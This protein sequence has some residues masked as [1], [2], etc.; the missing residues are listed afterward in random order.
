MGIEG[1]DTFCMTFFLMLFIGVFVMLE[2]A[3]LGRDLAQAGVEH[4]L[5]G[6]P[7]R[8]V[9]EVVR[10]G[11]GLGEVLIERQCPG[12]GAGHLGNLDRVGEPGPVMVTLVIDE[13]LRLVLQPTEGL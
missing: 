6:M 9:T 10:Q 4:L 13:N 7:E 1:E 5:T 8:G 3:A 12:D 11:D 2:A